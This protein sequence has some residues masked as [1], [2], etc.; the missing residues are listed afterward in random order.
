MG[1][2]A[3]VM[4]GEGTGAI[5]T[6]Q[7][8]GR[9]AAAVLGKIFVR[10]GKKCARFE[11][12][13]I[14]LGS[15]VD[16]ER[17][18]DQV[19]IGCEAPLT[20]AI[21][22]HGNPLIVE[23]I[24]ELLDKSGVVLVGAEELLARTLSADKSLNAIAI[25]SRLAQLKAKTL[26]GTK[27]IA[28]QIDSGLSTMLA[29]WL[30]NIDSTA[31]SDITDGAARI[32][33]DSEVARLIMFGCTT[34]L[35]GPPN[36]GKSTLLNCLAGREKAIVTDIGGTT[37]DWVGAECRIG[38]LLLELIDT[39]G[40]DE[41]LGAAAETVEKAAQQKSAEMLE[42]ADVVLLVLDGSQPADQLNMLPIEKLSAGKVV[43][44]LNKSDLPGQFDIAGLPRALGGPVRISAKLQTGIDGLREEI[45]RT[46]GAARFDRKTPVCFTPRQQSL[47][48]SLTL[49]ISK[50]HA[51]R[52]LNQ[53]L[54]GCRTPLD[55]Y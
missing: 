53:L 21:N 13:Q 2:F 35:A 25:E 33:A 38:P 4:T 47:L 44:I 52:T 18:I 6:I 17:I 9:D 23:M 27:I 28:N 39:A 5:A 36:S 14:L 49:A 43:T 37:R 11:T 29:K 48:Q 20:F 30:D 34:V 7:L 31:L 55:D 22:C 16:G 45:L 8:Y 26:E 51:R 12:G 1:A 41:K 42:R 50:D 40:L 54:N 24:M 3:A 10:A 19:T 15:V 32:L 46:T